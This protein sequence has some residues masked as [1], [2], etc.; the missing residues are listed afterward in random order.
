MG[1]P[2]QVAGPPNPTSGGEIQWRLTSTYIQQYGADI[3]TKGTKVR[4]VMLTLE[5]AP[6]KWMVALHNDD[7]S[8]LHNFNHFIMVL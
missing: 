2:A 5:G 7:A 6:A 8:E 3:V 4:V 1:R